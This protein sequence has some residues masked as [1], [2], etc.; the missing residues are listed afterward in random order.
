VSPSGNPATTT[1]GPGV[2]GPAKQTSKTTATTAPPTTSS[3]ILVP[4]LIGDNVG[5]AETQLQDKGLQFEI[6]YQLT[7]SNCEVTAQ[8][9]QSPS[10]VTPGTIVYLTVDADNNGLCTNEPV[11]P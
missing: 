7:N 6:E 9:P 10:E 2:A 11:P 4:N 5:F 8:S 3:L 1:A